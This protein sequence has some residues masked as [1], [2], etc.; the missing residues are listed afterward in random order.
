MTVTGLNGSVD[1]VGTYLAS[2]AVSLSVTLA[3]NVALRTEGDLQNEGSKI[4][5][6]TG[7]FDAVSKL[8]AG[9][10]VTFSGRFIKGKKTCLNETSLTTSGGMTDPAFLF[11]FTEVRASQ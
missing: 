9:Q 8:A 11:A 2:E 3:P 6:G 5:R 7:L 1:R 4:Q 10:A